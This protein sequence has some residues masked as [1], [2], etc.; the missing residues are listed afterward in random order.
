MNIARSRFVPA[1]INTYDQLRHTLYDPNFRLLRR[2]A[3]DSMIEVVIVNNDAI[4]LGDPRFITSFEFD[5]IFIS[6]TTTVIPVINN[7]RLLTYVAAQYNNNIF[8]II[9]ILW[10]ERNQITSTDVFNEIRRVFITGDLAVIYAD[11]DLRLCAQNAFPNAQVIAT[12]DSFCRIIHQNAQNLDINIGNIS[13]REFI[14]QVM[15]IILLPADEIDNAFLE[16]VNHLHP[17][18]RDELNRLINYINNVW[19]QENVMDLT[20][21]FNTPMGLTNV[22]ILL[23]RDFQ[24]RLGANP[25]I[26]EFLKKYI[27]YINAAKSDLRKL[28]ENPVAVITRFPRAH[29]LCIEKL[30]LV[31]LW[32]LLTRQEITANEFLERMIHLQQNYFNDLIYNSELLIDEQLVINEVQNN[33]NQEVGVANENL[34]VVADEPGQNNY[35]PMICQLCNE[36]PIGIVCVPCLHVQMCSVC[37][38]SAQDAANA[39]HRRLQCPF[40]NQRATFHEGEFRENPNGDE[41]PF[42][43]CEICNINTINIICIPCLHICVCQMCSNERTARGNNNCPTCD[44]DT[45]FR[46]AY[47]P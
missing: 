20:S 18:V 19:I 42:M 4:I 26:W 45:E 44:Q 22:G 11:F 28:Q 1:I 33:E 46:R 27:L 38:Q 7:T 29:H 13:N 14:Q 3:D 16:L 25:T 6:T 32:K 39:E 12:Y 9:T 36:H 2:Y 37:S 31:R 34:E 47:F 5:T 35:R 15:N 10:S 41:F 21:L 40:C 17:M 23:T 30:L 43:I 24:N 8:P